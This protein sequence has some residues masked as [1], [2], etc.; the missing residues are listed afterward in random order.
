[1][2]SAKLLAVLLACLAGSLLSVEAQK[3][4]L[5]ATSVVGQFQS[6]GFNPSIAGSDPLGNLPLNDSRLQRVVTGFAP[7]QVVASLR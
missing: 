3:R 4:E 7:E 2:G 6:I 1:M 5:Q